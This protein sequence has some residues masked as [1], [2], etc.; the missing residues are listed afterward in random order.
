MSST[1]INNYDNHLPYKVILLNTFM[2]ACGFSAWVAFG[3]SNRAI[4]N[5][6]GL[7]LSQAT[8]LKSI[9]IL[10]GATLR[11]PIGMLADRFGARLICPLVLLFGTLAAIGI[12]LSQSFTQLVTF[13]TCLGLVG[14]TF[15]VGA[16]SVSSWSPQTKQ[17]IA[18]GIFGAGNVGTAITTLG[19]PFLLNSFNWR[20]GF[21]TYAI[22]LI[23]VAFIYV[24]FIRNAPR[25]GATPTLKQLLSPLTKLQV[26]RFS[27]YYMATFGV[28]V[29]AT[30]SLS[31][32]YTEGYQISIQHA[33]ILATTFTF[34][35]SLIRILGGKLSDSFGARKVVC[36]CQICVAI[37]LCP[38]LFGI[39]LYACVLCVFISGLA[40]G[41]GMAGVIRYIPQ[42]FPQSVGAVTGIVGAIGGLGGF[43]LPLLSTLFKQIFKTVYIQVAPF[44]ILA[45]IAILVQYFA[46]RTQKIASLQNSTK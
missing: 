28:F 43:F 10:F 45:I 46:I 37:F 30:L 13:A 1:N 44:I 38:V 41:I 16:Q 40:M 9:P 4:A 6:L 21:Q 11:I 29:A 19:L 2:F 24:V 25:R 39:P 7:S 23:S 12:S 27:L 22:I 33:G 34:S 5:E 35:C 8:L 20:I 3:P 26:W 32:I 15:A 31:D 36:I 14:T 17:G 42:Y 18:L